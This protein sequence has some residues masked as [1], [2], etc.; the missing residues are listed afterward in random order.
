MIAW[1]VRFGTHLSEGEGNRCSPLT[2]GVYGA[3]WLKCRAGDPAGHAR[4]G[5]SGRAC[6]DPCSRKRRAASAEGR[7]GTAGLVERAFRQRAQAGQDFHGVLVPK[8]PLPAQTGIA[9]ALAEGIGSSELSQIASA[10]T[11]WSLLDDCCCASNALRAGQR[12]C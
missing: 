11:V 2:L 7:D 6:T 8:A 5:L 12:R 10:F 4:A 1:S 9:I 3:V